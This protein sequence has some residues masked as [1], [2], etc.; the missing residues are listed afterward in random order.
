M[1]ADRS[2]AERLAG[3][4][5]PGRSPLN[6]RTLQRFHW[7][8]GS[9]EPYGYW[10]LEQRRLFRILFGLRVPPNTPQEDQAFV[11]WLDQRL[12][13]VRRKAERDP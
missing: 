11:A 1:K 10:M 6:C 13:S 7:L 12:A 8:S 9:R 5:R 3:Q 2:Q 4:R